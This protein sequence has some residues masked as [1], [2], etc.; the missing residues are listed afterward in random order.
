MIEFYLKVI[1]SLTIALDIQHGDC[2]ILYQIFSH[3]FNRF[4]FYH[5]THE[6]S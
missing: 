2:A 5:D 3:Q 4:L 1:R 6:L